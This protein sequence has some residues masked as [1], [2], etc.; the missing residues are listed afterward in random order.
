MRKR[1][2]EPVSSSYNTYLFIDYTISH[3]YDF[4]TVSLRFCHFV[5][6]Q[7]LVLY[8][9]WLYFRNDIFKTAVFYDQTFLYDKFYWFPC[10]YL[11]IEKNMIVENYRQEKHL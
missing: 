8:V 4:A 10:E 1:S 5:C 9:D 2:E 11:Q 6:G 7:N 3:S